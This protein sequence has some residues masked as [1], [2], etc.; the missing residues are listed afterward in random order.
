MARIA[1]RPIARV[2]PRL[3]APVDIAPLV[4]FRIAFGTL[5][6]V[7]MRRYFAN[8][9][10]R[11]LY[12]EPRFHFT[13]LGFDWVRPWS[14][15]GMFLHFGLLAACAALIA[16]GA[17]YRVAAALFCVGFTYVFL[18]DAALYQNHLYLI[19][20]L[21]FLLVFV[22]AHRA[23][24]VDALVHPDSQTETVPAW[25]LWLLR[26]QLGIVY[27][28]AGLAKLNGDWLRGEPTR[29][30]LA[31][32]RDV[33]MLEPVLAPLLDHPWAPYVVNYGGL[34][35]DLTIV[36]LLLWRRTRA[37]AVPL[38]LLFHSTNSLLFPIGI[39]PWLM[40]AALPLLLPPASSRRVAGRLRPPGPAAPS[41][42][43]P[44]PRL[45]SA[46]L[47]SYLALQ[48]LVPLRHL[49]YPGNPSWTGEGDRFAWRMMLDLKEGAVVFAVE[50]PVDG[51][52]REVDPRGELAPWQVEKLAIRPDLILQY[53]HHLRDAPR[54]AGRPPPRVFAVAAVA[55]NGRPARPLVDP[56]VDLAAQSR[57]LAPTGWVPPLTEPLPAPVD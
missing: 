42:A 1:S 17:Y 46:L 14:G 29:L 13:Y 41:P 39:F 7:E 56:A 57:S 54:P 12:V 5:M 49:L 32:G 23:A 20:L 25:A 43:R 45:V 53:A 11:A 31:R 44:P 37:L 18:L 28:F 4:W 36:P 10:V 55:L 51:G 22:P 6:F 8:D 47:L 38:A 19:C 2:A 40:I 24:S 26:A 9:W 3:L 16:I 35:L 48:L 15:D 50:D 21:S 52:Q 33:G 34:L 27:T 30:F